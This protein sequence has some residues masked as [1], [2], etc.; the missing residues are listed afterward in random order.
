MYKLFDSK[1]DIMQIIFLDDISSIN[2]NI[3]NLKGVKRMR[4]RD[5]FWIIKVLVT[6]I[7]VQRNCVTLDRFDLL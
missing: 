4:I 5:Y 3:V 2:L 6:C 1:Q 7:I